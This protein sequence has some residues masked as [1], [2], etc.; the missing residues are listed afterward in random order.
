[1]LLAVPA[2]IFIADSILKA[3]RS[4]ILSSAIFFTSS[5]LTEATF[6]LLDS[7]DPFFI[8]ADSNSWTAAGGVF[9]IKL[10]GY[11]KII[12]IMKQK[13]LKKINLQNRIKVY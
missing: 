12:I 5:Q 11:M 7:G 1:M 3:F 13:Y 10:K 9:I 4:C 2:T 6:C 8:L